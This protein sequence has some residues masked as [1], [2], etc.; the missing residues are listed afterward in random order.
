MGE[1]IDLI[2][3]PADDNAR[4]RQFWEGLVAARLEAPR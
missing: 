4:A 2:E 1:P 3:F